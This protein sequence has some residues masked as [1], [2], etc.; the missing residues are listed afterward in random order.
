MTNQKSLTGQKLGKYLLH[1]YRLCKN[2]VGSRRSE[3]TALA[4]HYTICE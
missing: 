4:F 2:E 1:P 3:N